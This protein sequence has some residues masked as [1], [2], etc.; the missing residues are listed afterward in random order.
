VSKYI[1][2]YV[3]SELCHLEG[4]KLSQLHMVCNEIH[5]YVVKYR[6]IIKAMFIENNGCLFPSWVLP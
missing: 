4:Y 5:L 2:H 6:R 1:C 3:N